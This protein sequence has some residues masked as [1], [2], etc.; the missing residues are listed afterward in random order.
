M[1]TPTSHANQHSKVMPAERH[2]APLK[3]KGKWHYQKEERLQAKLLH[4]DL[5][6]LNERIQQHIFIS[7][8]VLY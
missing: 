3:A 1:Q 5:K 8:T 2:S 4:T 6:K 7:R